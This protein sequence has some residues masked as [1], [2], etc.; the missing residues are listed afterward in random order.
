M[1]QNRI[2]MK[3]KLTHILR[4]LVIFFFFVNK[5]GGGG[6]IAFTVDVPLNHRLSPEFSSVLLLPLHPQHKLTPEHVLSTVLTVYAGFILKVISTL[7][8]LGRLFRSVCV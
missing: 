1:R 4:Q 3:T 6:V 7:S 2:E 5:A 8:Y